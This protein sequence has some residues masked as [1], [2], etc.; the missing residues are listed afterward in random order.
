MLIAAVLLVFTSVCNAA[1]TVTCPIQGA[2]KCVCV[3]GII[4]CVGHSL[5]ATPNFRSSTMRFYHVRLG[6]ND[7]TSTVKNAFASLNSSDIDLSFNQISILDIQTFGGVEPFLKI[8]NLTHN[9]LTVLPAAIASLSVLQTLDISWNPIAVTSHSAPDFS[10][11]IMRHIGDTIINL[12]FGSTEMRAWPDS[13]T[14]LNQLQELTVAGVHLV[15]WPP[16]AFHGFERTLL[17]L[18]IEDL[19]TEAVPIG[20]AFLTQLQELSLN[21]LQYPFSDDSLISLPF[22]QLSGTLMKLTLKNDSLTYFPDGIK[23]LTSL[24]SLTLDGNDLEFVSDE[25]ILLLK[26]ANVTDLS[27]QSCN[28][29]RV[30]GAISDLINLQ[31]LDLSTNIIRSIESTDLQNLANLR[32]LRLS[33]NPLKYISDNSLCGLER[34]EVTAH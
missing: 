29:K 27:L 8:L 6:H 16:G 19:S 4:D 9:Q 1:T 14:H 21:N 7:I 30:P 15:Y 20:I 3:P 12:R 17:K 24:Q 33:Y 5:T 28:L 25:A 32:T 18:T 2:T 11:D 26:S 34:L 22:S 13:L 10:G 31:L 23:D